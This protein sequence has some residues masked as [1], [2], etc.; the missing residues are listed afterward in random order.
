MVEYYIVAVTVKGSSPFI[1]LR[2]DF[3]IISTV[4]RKTWSAVQ[5]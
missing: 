4:L 1:H 3:I 2:R 5:H